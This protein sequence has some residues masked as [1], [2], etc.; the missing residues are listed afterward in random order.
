MA[1][2]RRK[3]T[4]GALEL[5]PVPKERT[6]Y[7][8]DTEVRGLRLGVHPTKKRTFSLL[9]KSRGRVVTFP[10]GEF[11][12]VSIEQARRQASEKIAAL[13]R[14]E[15]PR[16]EL[17]GTNNPPLGDFFQKRYLKEHTRN[18]V[19]LTHQQQHDLQ[20][21]F[22]LY[23]KPWK[24]R[25]L[26][27]ILR[28]DVER[29]MRQIGQPRTERGR[30]R[31]GPVAANRLLA[32]LSSIFIDA[33]NWGVFATD[34]PT[35]GVKKFHEQ[36]RT[37]VIE[38]GDEHAKF[39]TAL[40]TEANRD[41]RD[42]L[43]VRLTTGVR[44][45]NI[46]AAR[47]ED[48]DVERKRWKIGQTKN[49]DPLLVTLSPFVLENVFCARER[50]GPWVFPAR[51]GNGHLKS[52]TKSWRRFREQVGMPDLQLRDLRRTFASRLLANGTPM[53]VIAQAV[54]H[55]P[56]STITASVYAMADENV[57]RQAVDSTVTAMLAEVNS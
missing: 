22:D 50:K 44:G 21:T 57:K 17:R 4:K 26:S 18:N 6:Y 56:G 15:N 32:L 51:R 35:R 25:P 12:H 48:I 16:D 39:L 33:R 37:R 1:N 46:F 45:V 40:S 20:R 10:L 53:S 31:G 8:Y 11:P 52:L 24:N 19:S 49:G 7:V 9:K 47:W 27:M 43:T 28:A 30:K 42:Y 23:L 54:G 55:K 3:F 13:A 41:L 36:P 5:I 2:D 38:R 29:L 34:P 14:G